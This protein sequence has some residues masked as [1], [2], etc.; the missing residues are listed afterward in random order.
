[1]AHNIEYLRCLVRHNTKKEVA[2]VRFLLKANDHR[3]NIKRYF[4]AV[5]AHRTGGDPDLIE[6]Y[7]LERAYDDVNAERL[8]K[9]RGHQVEVNDFREVYS[10]AINEAVKKFFWLGDL[11][12]PSSLDELVGENKELNLD[13]ADTISE[14]NLSQCSDDTTSDLKNRVFDKVTAVVGLGEPEDDALCNDYNEITADLNDKSL[15]I[16]TTYRMLSA[17]YPEYQQELVAR[18]L[19]LWQEKTKELCERFAE[20]VANELNPVDQMLGFKRFTTDELALF[21]GLRLAEKS[22]N[23]QSRTTSVEVLEGLDAP[24]SCDIQVGR[25]RVYVNPQGIILNA[26]Y[27]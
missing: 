19:A 2:T 23:L 3:S 14:L 9:L 10:E 11:F 17:K 1:M 26:A 18:R 15:N 12:V 22:D 4:V 16:E 8:A 27:E 13:D 6:F 7:Q 24:K 21:N 25:L 5:G 20:P